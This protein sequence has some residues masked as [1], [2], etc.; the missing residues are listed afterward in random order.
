MSPTICDHLLSADIGPEFGDVRPLDDVRMRTLSHNGVHLMD[1]IDSNESF[2]S[3][4]ASPAVGFITWSQ[5][6]H[7]LTMQQSRDRNDKLLDFL[8][9]RSACDFKS[10]IRVLANYQPHLVSL[11]ETDGGERFH[12]I[13]TDTIYDTIRYGRRV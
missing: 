2:I 4:L 11:L 13:C 1:L 6:D 3:E 7:I 9:R 10:F 12:R 8:T 5:R